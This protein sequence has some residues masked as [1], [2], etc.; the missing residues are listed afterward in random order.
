MSYLREYIC[1]S[2]FR[3]SYNKD[4][5]NVVNYLKINYMENTKISLNYSG[6][7]LV[8]KGNNLRIKKLLDEELLIVGD[9]ENIEIK[10]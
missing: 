5:L 1:D 3:F 9:I 4:K 8:V 6:G 2:I 7:N 10:E